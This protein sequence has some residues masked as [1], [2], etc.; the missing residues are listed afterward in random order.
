M[1][2]VLDGVDAMVRKGVADPGHLGISGISY[3][4]Y[5]TARTITRD[6]RFKTAILVSGISNWIGIHTGQTAAPEAAQKM[7]WIDNPY[8]ITDLLWDRSPTAH[9][10][11]V[12][13]ATLIFWGEFDPAIPVSQ[14][15]ELYRGLRHFGVPSKLIVYPRDGHVPRERNHM[16]DQY[17]RMTDWLR[18]YL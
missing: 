3:G 17:T 13:S 16:Q 10:K 14:A 8:D 6:T 9:L 18:K 11:D 5:L 2:D 4:G 1:T 12:K 7:E 15:I